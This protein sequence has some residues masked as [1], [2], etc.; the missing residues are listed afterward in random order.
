MTDADPMK[1]IV[2]VK[3]K[4]FRPVEEYLQAQGRFSHLFKP[5][6]DEVTLKRIQEDVD[7]KL[8]WVGL[9]Q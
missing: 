7:R 3:P 1:P 5:K 9:K 6:R 4:E 2:T 8:K